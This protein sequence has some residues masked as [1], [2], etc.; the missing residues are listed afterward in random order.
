MTQPHRSRTVSM[1]SGSAYSRSE[2]TRAAPTQNEINLDDFPESGIAPDAPVWKKYVEETDRFDKELVN[3]WNNLL[4]MLLH[5]YAIPL[6][7]GY[8]FDN[9]GLQ[10]L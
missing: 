7:D 6:F 8:N 1:H 4:D 2:A 10:S 3:G 5:E 9:T